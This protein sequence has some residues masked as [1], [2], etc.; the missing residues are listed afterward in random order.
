[1]AAGVGGAPTHS[2]NTVRVTASSGKPRILASVSAVVL[3]LAVGGG[4]L[5]AA[6]VIA[7]L[8]TRGRSWLLFQALVGVAVAIV[9]WRVAGAAGTWAD[10]DPNGCSDCGEGE[11][12][13]LILLV[14]NVIGWLVGTAL[15]APIGLRRSR[16]RTLSHS[17]D[18]PG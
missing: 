15:G 4:A 18:E 5:L 17:H 7:A 6:A 14:G 2:V 13:G 9:A 12:V 16:R 3:V 1:V 8:F 10:E 11:L